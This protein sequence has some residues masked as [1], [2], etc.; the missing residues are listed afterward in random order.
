MGGRVNHLTSPAPLVGWKSK[1]LDI[2]TTIAAN[3]LRARAWRNFLSHADP[4]TID[5][6]AFNLKWN[7]AVALLQGLGGL[8]TCMTT[9][10]TCSLDPNHA[11]VVKSLMDFHQKEIT[12]LKGE[13][14]KYTKDLKDV[15]DALLQ[16][17]NNLKDTN[18]EAIARHNTVLQQL[19][20]LSEELKEMKKLEPENET[21]LLLLCSS[22][23]V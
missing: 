15:R 16:K 14:A 8:V 3:V 5:Q 9:L 22:I 2:D 17:Q 1:P 12:T 18:K 7:E 20:Y 4:K 19:Q 23:F 11:P 10:Q 21:G 6:V 13:V